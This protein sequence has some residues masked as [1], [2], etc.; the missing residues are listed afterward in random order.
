M[1]TS[2]DIDDLKQSQD[3]LRRADERTRLIVET[4]LDAVVTMNS[5]GLITSW[6]KQAESD[7]RLEC[8]GGHRPAAWPT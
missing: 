2:T 6:N 4:A 1:G 8:R 5:Q 7:L 3:D